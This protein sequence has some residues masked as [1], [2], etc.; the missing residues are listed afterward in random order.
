[1]LFS[2]ALFPLVLALTLV[3]KQSLPV[4]PVRGRP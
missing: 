2:V 3:A 1:M 4:G